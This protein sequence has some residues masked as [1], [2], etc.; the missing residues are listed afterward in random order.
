MTAI[1]YT[2]KR[3]LISGHT[4]DTSYN[5]ETSAVD[6]TPSH[7]P[8][9]AAKNVTLDGT[10]EVILNR[11][12]KTY[13][14]TTGWIASASLDSWWEFFDSVGAAEAFTFD[15]FGTIAS[16]DNP[17]SVILEG[18]PNAGHAKKGALYQFSFTVRVAT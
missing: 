2:A 7:A 5:L 8:D 15:A 3:S 10:T 9:T 17:L 13:Q 12:D 1:T 4:V 14:V 6:V 16:P 18:E 11:I